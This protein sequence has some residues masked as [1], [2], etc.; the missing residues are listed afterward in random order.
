MYSIFFFRVIYRGVHTCACVLF[1]HGAAYVLRSV[2]IHACIHV[3]TMFRCVLP[4]TPVGSVCT[5]GHAS[6]THRVCVFMCVNALTT[7]PDGE[8]ETFVHSAL[9]EFACWGNFSTAVKVKGSLTFV[10]SFSTMIITDGY[11]TTIAEV[12]CLFFFPRLHGWDFEDQ[13]NASLQSSLWSSSSISIMFLSTETLSSFLPFFLPCTLWP[14]G[15]GCSCNASTP[16]PHVF[17]HIAAS[18]TPPLCSPIPLIYTL[19]S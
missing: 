13:L 15:Q 3:S 1:Y 4:L 8:V 19:N 11:F 10:V 9:K 6:R 12:R 2:H 16:T 7:C 17:L 14:S 5:Y 18:L